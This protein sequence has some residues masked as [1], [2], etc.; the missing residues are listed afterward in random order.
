ML[1]L[2]RYTEKIHKCLLQGTHLI[3]DNQD[4]YDVNTI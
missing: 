3:I 4:K 2:R 1:L